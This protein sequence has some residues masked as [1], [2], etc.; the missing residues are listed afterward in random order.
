MYAWFIKLARQK[1]GEDSSGILPFTLK[2]I[3]AIN[4]Y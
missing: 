1:K 4:D 3:S 2:K